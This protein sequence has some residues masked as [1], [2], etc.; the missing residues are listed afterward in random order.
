MDVT[1]NPISADSA[2]LIVLEEAS[3]SPDVS[4]SRDALFG[5]NPLAIATAKAAALESMIKILVQDLKFTD[6]MREILLICMRSVKSEAGSILE[7]DPSSNTLFF[8]AAA[9]QSSDTISGFRVPVGQGIA[10]HVAESRQPIVVANVAENEI[11]LKAIARAVGFEARNM[12]AV[13]IVVRGKVFG[14]LELL[15]RFGDPDY[16]QGDVDFLV[17]LCEMAG[18]AVEVR[19][20]FAWTKVRAA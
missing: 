1:D 18:K 15:N 17:Y 3:S 8:R 5:D 16:S 11:H 20:M 12:V 13:P 7:I 9:G 4:L 19:L 6:F 14:V 2:P 10:G